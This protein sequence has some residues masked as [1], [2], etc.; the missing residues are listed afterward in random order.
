M[1]SGASLMTFAAAQGVET[2]IRVGVNSG[3]VVVRSIGSDLRMD[4]TAVGQTTHL[5]ARKEQLALPGSIRLTEGDAAPCREL[6]RSDPLG[7][8]LIKGKGI[9]APIEVF[10]LMGAGAARTRFRAA[11]PSD[12]L[13]EREAELLPVGY[14]H[15]VYTTTGTDRRHRLS[16]QA[17]DLRPALQGR[18]GNNARRP[19]RLGAAPAGPRTAVDADAL[20]SKLLQ[21]R[22]TQAAQQLSRSR[23]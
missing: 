10:E 14:F 18:H 16:E 12:W 23:F 19:A 3:D 17:G 6:H 8:V 7:P 22:F 2:Q 21:S 5:A 1:Q 15:I 11:A 4:Y 20:E 13:A 9:A